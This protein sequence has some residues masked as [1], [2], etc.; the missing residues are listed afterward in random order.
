MNRGS[1][2]NYS[3]PLGSGSIYAVCK[4]QCLL[5]REPPEGNAARA[6]EKPARNR[7]RHAEPAGPSLARDGSTDPPSPAPE[8]SG[9][10]RVKHVPYFK[11]DVKP[12][13][14]FLKKLFR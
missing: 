7:K 2:I 10:S 6:A 13:F 5:T 8:T 1:D 11:T 9:S 4:S 12:I 3:E 14:D